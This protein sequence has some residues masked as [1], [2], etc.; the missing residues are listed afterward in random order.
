MSLSTYKH[1]RITGESSDGIEGAIRTA[2]E[3]SAKAVKGHSWFEVVDIRGS[4]GSGGRIE[5][6]QVTLEIAFAVIESE[7]E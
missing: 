5:S 7:M 3:T 4:L 6:Y 1:A 2:L